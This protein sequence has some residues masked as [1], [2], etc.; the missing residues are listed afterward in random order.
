MAEYLSTVTDPKLRKY[1][2]M[3]RLSSTAW[4]SR[5]TDRD[6]P[7]SK[8]RETVTHCTQGE[9]E[10][11]LHFLTT[12]PL[13]QDIRDIYFPQFANTQSDFENK[14]N[15]EKL[16]YL[17]GEIQQCANTAARFVSCCDKK[18]TTSGLQPP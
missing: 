7:A 8:R 4:L 12:C 14:T 11:E 6:K 16:P 17:L 1:V 2:T 15:I 10:T 3:Y 13:Y 9:L 5:K 18:R